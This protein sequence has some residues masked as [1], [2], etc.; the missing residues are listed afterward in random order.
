VFPGLIGAEDDPSCLDHARLIAI[1]VGKSEVQESEIER[2][3]P[4]FRTLEST[5]D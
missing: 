2:L 1:F 5:R 3:K 4:A